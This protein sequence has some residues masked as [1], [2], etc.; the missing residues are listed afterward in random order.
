MLWQKALIVSPP[1]KQ[2]IMLFT[3][4]KRRFTQKLLKKRGIIVELSHTLVLQKVN[5][6]TIKEALLYMF[7]QSLPYTTISAI[8]SVD[9]LHFLEQDS[10][11]LATWKLPCENVPRTKRV[12]DVDRQM[13]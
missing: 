13:M 9:F 2:N 4:K 1:K 5:Y 3:Q 10:V 6:R 12:D 7:S 8:F 11:A